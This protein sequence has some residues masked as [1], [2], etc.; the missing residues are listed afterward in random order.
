MYTIAQKSNA[1]ELYLEFEKVAEGQ[2]GQ[3]IQT[4][5]SDQG[6]KCLFRD[7][8]HQVSPLG[9]R[10]ELTASHTAHQNTVAE[11]MIRTPL[12]Q[13]IAMLQHMQVYRV[14]WEEALSTK[15]YFINRA[16]SRALP[17]KNLLIIF[18]KSML[19]LIGTFVSLDASAGL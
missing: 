6:G 19:L 18:C 17:S 10:H 14:L 7:L 13:T 3:C 1:K 4:V 15:T 12:S 2:A 11:H 8:K 5:R 16:T 9:I